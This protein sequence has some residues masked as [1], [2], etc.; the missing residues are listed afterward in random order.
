MARVLQANG[1]VLEKWVDNSV[2]LVRCVVV[3]FISHATLTQLAQRRHCAASYEPSD[4][5]SAKAV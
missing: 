3:P 4:P 5:S 2:D 1:D